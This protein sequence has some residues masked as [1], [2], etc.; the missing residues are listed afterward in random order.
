M[1][2]VT[3]QRQPKYT[4]KWGGRTLR[5]VVYASHAFLAGCKL[6]HAPHPAAARRPPVVFTDDV[7]PVCKTPSAQGYVVTEVPAALGGWA[8]IVVDRL[9]KIADWLNAKAKDLQK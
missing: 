7:C 3:T 8:G 4:K 9:Y 2:V 5:P 6:C 1:A